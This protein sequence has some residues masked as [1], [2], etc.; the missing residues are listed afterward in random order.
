MNFLAR[1][2]VTYLLNG[3][4]VTVPARRWTVFWAAPPH[5]L[6]DARQAEDFTWF[7]IPLAWV[8][9]WSLPE[10]FLHGL[11]HG[12][13]AV[14]E[15]GLDDT[16]AARWRR[17]MKRRDSRWREV[18]VLEIQALFLRLALEG[19]SAGAHAGPA[20]TSTGL[21][22]VESMARFL[23]THYR[24]DIGPEAVAR[25]VGLQMNYAMG[26]FREFSGQTVVESL[27][28]HRVSHAQRLLA[29]T[30]RKILDIALESGFGSSSRFY[31]AFQKASRQTPRAYRQAMRLPG[32][33]EG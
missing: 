14:A 24:E 11:L 10:D 16:A 33:R 13:V 7:T 32:S 31:A 25:Q 3:R 4:L 26:L 18:I 29:T 27:T 30:D 12:R 8:L 2:T 17:W 28:R 20:M 6:I 21:R 15:E 23:A 19:G 22:H 1:G 9:G 5:R